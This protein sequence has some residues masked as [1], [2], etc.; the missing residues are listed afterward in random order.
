MQ[1]QKVMF[2][3][4]MGLIPILF[5]LGGTWE[6]GIRRYGIP[7]IIALYLGI[8]F[9]FHWSLVLGFG[10][11][12]GVLTLGYGDNSPFPIMRWA[13]DGKVR[14]YIGLVVL[15]CLYCAVNWLECIYLGWE[16]AKLIALMPAAVMCLFA[17]L[18]HKEINGKTDRWT[19]W[20][21]LGG[22][23]ACAIGFATI[24]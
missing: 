10:L 23:A 7:S 11:R 9:G 12:Y 4:V 17:F 3:L 14:G 18:L 15:G 21:C 16:T 19:I 5:V 6:K 22:G 8:S 2:G 1:W 13:N 24:G 20:E